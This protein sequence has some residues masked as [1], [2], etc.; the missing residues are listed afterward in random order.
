[1]SEQGKSE[2]R[3]SKTKGKVIH[4]SPL[5]ERKGKG[6]TQES[7]MRCK[8]NSK[9]SK[10]ILQKKKIDIVIAYEQG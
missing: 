9:S 3:E 2:T 7:K 1:M 4:V 10:M 6:A 8:D 5:N